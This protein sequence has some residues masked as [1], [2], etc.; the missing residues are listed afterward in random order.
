LWRDRISGPRCERVRPVDR[1]R[2]RDS[3]RAMAMSLLSARAAGIAAAR[4]M[5]GWGC[6]GRVTLLCGG[7]IGTSRLRRPDGVE[8][9]PRTR[10]AL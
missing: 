4:W 2:R 6:S 5:T 1:Q 3:L 10:L 8:R 7:G 9:I